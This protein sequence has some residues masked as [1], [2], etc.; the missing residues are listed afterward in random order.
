MIWIHGGGYAFGA[1]DEQVY[2]PDFLLQKN[3]ILVTIAYRTGAL[4]IFLKYLVIV[5]GLT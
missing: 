5:Y 4:G 1:P 3:I 2:G